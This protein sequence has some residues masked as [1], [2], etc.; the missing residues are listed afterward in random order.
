MSTHNICFLE[1]IEK[2][3]FF[4]GKKPNIFS[5]ELG[6]RLPCKMTP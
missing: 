2:Y 1:E 4:L 5:S 6:G 3:P